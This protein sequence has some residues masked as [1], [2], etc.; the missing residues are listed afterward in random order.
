MSMHGEFVSALLDPER[1]APG[2]VL[3]AGGR[4][5]IYRNNVIASLSGAL[6]K[7]F[8]VV[9]RMLGKDYFRALAAA[10][11]RQ[12]PPKARVVAEYGTGFPDFIAGFE[13]LRDFAYLCDVARL[14]LARLQALRA[15][16]AL[17][18]DPALAGDPQALLDVRLRFHPSARLVRSAFPIAD[19]WAAHQHENVESPA[20]WEG[21]DVLVSRLDARV[22]HLVLSPIEADF[23]SRL[24]DFPSLGDALFALGDEEAAAAALMGLCLGLLQSECL[25]PDHP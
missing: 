6:G 17:P 1:A 20:V 25:V 23:L 11:V 16:D 21:Q 2:G 3:A 7:T 15:A 10:F 24:P 9:R 12:H 18:A 19:L 8:P 4:F 22:S 5:D 14:E 13:H